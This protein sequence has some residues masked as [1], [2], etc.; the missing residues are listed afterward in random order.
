M[1][2][3]KKLASNTFTFAI[4]TFSSK[5]LVFLMLP[6][7]TRTLSSAEYGEVDLVVQAC[8]LMIPLASAGIINAVIRFGLDSSTNKKGVFSFSL[9]TCLLGFVLLWLAKPLFMNIDFLSA[10]IRYVYLFVFTAVLHSLCSN[11]I[12][13]QEY[14]RLYAF[15][16]VLRT[17]LTIIFN[18]VFLAVLRLG[19]AGYLLATIL[20]DAV[21]TV[22][23]FFSARLYRFFSLQS[24]D[25]G[26][27]SSMMKYALPL[28]PTM[29]SIWI[30]SLSD[31][32]ILSYLIGTEANGLY[33]IAY[34]IPTII[35]IMATIFMDAWQIS[36]VNEYQKKDSAHF[37]SRVYSVYSALVFTA[38]SVI[39]A[40]TKTITGILVSSDFYSAWQYIPILVLSTSFACFATFLSSI[41]MSEK[42]SGHVLL[43]TTISALINITLNFILIP[44]FGIQGAGISTLFSYL[45][46]F[47]IRAIHSRSFIKMNLGIPQLIINTAILLVQI[48]ILLI[49]SQSWLIYELVLATLVF[50]INL[51]PLLIGVRKV[52]EP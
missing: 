15:D 27:A 17:V 8:N 46:M 50:G 4:G 18:I 11:F 9:V 12:R 47:V 23:L 24:M 33:A 43:T 49:G 10:N 14:V 28:I 21:S 2:R 52:V 40:F 5:F 26:T 39:I 42:K 22:V 29:V 44:V 20:S 38:S 35:T 19:I 25:K 3:Y 30:I 48:I 32:Y 13:S 37:F 41:Y 7:Y 1:N 31:R 16:G 45:T 36:S 51:K 6:L 34:K